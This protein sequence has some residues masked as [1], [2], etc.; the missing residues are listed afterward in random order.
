MNIRYLKILIIAL[1]IGF[2]TQGCAVWI[3]DHD[4]DHDF[5]H[6]HWHSSLQQAKQPIA[7]M[8]AQ[9]NGDS[10]GS[11]RLSWKDERIADERRIE[12]E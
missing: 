3:H 5:H 4:Y 12:I 1:A 9:N 11:C 10:G 2:A 7:S 6:R 8:T